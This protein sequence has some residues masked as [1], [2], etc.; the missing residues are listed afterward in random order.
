MDVKDEQRIFQ[1]SPIIPSPFDGGACYII[2]R[3]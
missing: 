2:G 1:I 3:E